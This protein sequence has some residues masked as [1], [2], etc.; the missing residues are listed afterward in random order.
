MQF[1][2]EST[3]TLKGNYTIHWAINRKVW[4]KERRSKKRRKVEVYRRG[5][6]VERCWR[7]MCVCAGWVG[8][9]GGVWVGS[10]CFPLSKLLS[11]SCCCNGSFQAGEG[12][13]SFSCLSVCLSLLIANNALPVQPGRHRHWP[14]IGWQPSSWR[15]SHFFRQL[16]PNVPICQVGAE[17]KTQKEVIFKRTTVSVETVSV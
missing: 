6:A 10:V 8:V 7:C 2:N 13:E 11:C 16:G 5:K 1:K 9:G 15:Q 17:K 14:L 4:K 3:K 12:M